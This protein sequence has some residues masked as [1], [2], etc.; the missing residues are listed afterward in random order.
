MVVLIFLCTMIAFVLMNH[1][2]PYLPAPEAA[3]I[4]AAEPVFASLFAL[5]L[6]AWLSKLIGLSYA[7]EQLTLSLLVGGGL[8]TF[9]NVLIQGS[10]WRA[11]RKLRP[12]P[13]PVSNEDVAVRTS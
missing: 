11:A 8:I 12:S 5:F 6:P 2:Q 9:A 1:W 13:R 3:V 7:N 4:Y 10:A